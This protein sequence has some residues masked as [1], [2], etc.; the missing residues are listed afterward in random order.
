M[1]GIDSLCQDERIRI[2]EAVAGRHSLRATVRLTGV[3]QNRIK[4]LLMKLGP[5]CSQYQHVT[6]CHLPAASLEWREAFAFRAKANNTAA[7]HEYS[8]TTGSVWT[9]AC[10]DR[11]TKLVP[12][13]RIGPRTLETLGLLRADAA[14]RYDTEETAFVDE[15]DASLHICPT[16][17]AALDH[18]FARKVE[19]HAAVVALYFLYY[20]FAL[21]HRELGTTPAVAAG[22]ADHVWRAAEIVDL[23][24]SPGAIR[25]NDQSAPRQE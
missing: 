19:R 18:A 22:K 9:L 11:R 5:A 12:S 1:S 8:R 23:I 2:V 10:L 13:W 20:N 15:A 16:W 6:L 24:A 17:F 7:S 14:R 4:A 25:C 3:P 21:V